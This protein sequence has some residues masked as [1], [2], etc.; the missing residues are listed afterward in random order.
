MN[1]QEEESMARNAINKL[2]GEAQQEVPT[3]VVLPAI[4]PAAGCGSSNRKAESYTHMDHA[5]EIDGQPYT[6][7]IW[8]YA[9]CLDC[10]QR[11]RVRTYQNIP[12]EK[13]E[14]TPVPIG[15][16]SHGELKD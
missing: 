14:A 6:R 5:G 1:N 13:L 8:Y 9:T 10:G 3:V 2:T 4:C 16:T 15:F 7:I 11:Y 12:S